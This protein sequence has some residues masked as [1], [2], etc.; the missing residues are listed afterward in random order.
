[1]VLPDGGFVAFWLRGR[2]PSIVHLGSEGQQAV[3]APSWEAFL[4]KLVERRTRIY[5]LDDQE[6]DATVP[7]GW[8]KL[9]DA[10]VTPALRRDFKAWLKS[11]QPKPERIAPAAK[12]EVR[13][14]LVRMSAR[15]WKGKPDYL[16]WVDFIVT[17]TPK[18]YDARYYAGGLVPLP[19][20]A[21]MRPAFELLAAALGRALRRT[22]VSVHGDGDVFVDHNTQ[23]SPPG[24]KK[25]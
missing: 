1:M 11:C 5:D 7:P 3:V 19:D 22:A 25:R 10:K 2:A 8:R 9:R 16:R 23:L 13:K 21:R 24:A 14:R 20:A 6:G 4:R 18:R 17:L 15:Y 12:E